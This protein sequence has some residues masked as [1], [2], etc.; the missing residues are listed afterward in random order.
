M[1]VSTPPPEKKRRGRDEIGG[2]VSVESNGTAEEV[3]H[4]AYPEELKGEMYARGAP[5]GLRREGLRVQRQRAT[6]EAG[7]ACTTATRDGTGTGTGTGLELDW[8]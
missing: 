6:D 8:D 5:E 1:C 4:A 7:R 2:L 3:T